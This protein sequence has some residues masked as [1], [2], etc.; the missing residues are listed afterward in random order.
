M[1]W[2]AFKLMKLLIIACKWCLKGLV[3]PFYTRQNTYEYILKA[4]I[5]KFT[6]NNFENC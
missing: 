3:F 1:A 5:A 6:E 4:L 2:N